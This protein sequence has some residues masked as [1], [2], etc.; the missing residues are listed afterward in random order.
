MTNKK[1]ELTNIK[2]LNNYI[3]D[4]KKYY[5]VVGKLYGNY[6]LKRRCKNIFIIIYIYLWKQD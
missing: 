2:K 6:H 3:K 5:S 4:L 1:Y